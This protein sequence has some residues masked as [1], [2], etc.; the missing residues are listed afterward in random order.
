MR[1]FTAEVEG[2]FLLRVAADD[3]VPL[4]DE[5]GPSLQREID[6]NT[7]GGRNL[8]MTPAQK[9]AVRYLEAQKSLDPNRQRWLSAPL[10]ARKELVEG[11]RG[12]D[13]ALDDIATALPKA[14]QRVTEAL[15]EPWLLYDE[16]FRSHWAGDVSPATYPGE[17]AQGF[18]YELESH[19]MGRAGLSVGMP[20]RREQ[21]LAG[22]SK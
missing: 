1:D 2:R 21:H 19:F 20:F 11:L 13:K 14:R 17:G 7:W 12:L 18:I 9:L 3:D 22:G 4:E 8:E 6:R 10:A 15:K 16:D 5:I